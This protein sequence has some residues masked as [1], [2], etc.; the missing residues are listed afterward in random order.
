MNSQF[1][2]S[3]TGRASIVVIETD[4][5]MSPDSNRWNPASSI[6]TKAGIK[7]ASTLLLAGMLLASCTWVQLTSEGQSVSVRQADDVA[8]CQRLGRTQSQTTKS[9]LLIDRNRDKLSQEL[10]TLAR[11][12]AG[13]LGGNTI[14]AESGIAEGRQSFGVYRC[15]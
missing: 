10:I 8:A 1:S 6:G 4:A 15:P 13:S 7:G 5:G 2:H 14:A 9:V 3:S 12:E 11:N